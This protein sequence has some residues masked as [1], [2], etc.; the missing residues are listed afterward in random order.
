MADLFTVVT[1]K[2]VL[3]ASQIEGWQQGA[4]LQ[5]QARSRFL[6]GTPLIDPS[7]LITGNLSVGTFIKFSNNAASTTAL[8]DGEEITSTALVD[9]EINLTLAEY[10][11]DITVTAMGQN[12]SGA[13]A[14]IGA[15]GVVGNNLA[16]T[17]DTL[18]IK[19]LEAS[20]N[21]TI[22]TQSA[23]SSLTASDIL[24]PS[25]VNQARTSLV[26]RGVDPMFGDL[27]VALAHPDVIY[28]LKNS[29]NA[30]AWSQ[31]AKYSPDDTVLRSQMEIFGGFLWIESPFVS[32]NADAGSIA[33]DTY[34]TAFFGARALGMAMSSQFPIRT[35]QNDVH[36]KVPGRFT[37]IGWNGIFTFG[38]VDSDAV[39]LVTSASSI[40]A[41]S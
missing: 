3:D 33:V 2:A 22:V 25:Y 27:Y 4:I 12:S 20:S 41:N 30:N 36:S 14:F 15:A 11:H 1:D 26:K 38:I 17:V 32:V 34:H 23:E 35:Y 39:Q 29:T 7:N 6:P 37:S 19:A 28:D 5:S 24:T 10:G 16:K 9:S 40:G 31:V 13:R 18:A 8:T 21:E